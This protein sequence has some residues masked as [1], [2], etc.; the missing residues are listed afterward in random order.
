M[1]FLLLKE[2]AVKWIKCTTRLP[3]E[4]KECLVAFEIFPGEKHA[5]LCYNMATYINGVFLTWELGTTI[6][7]VTHWMPL[8]KSPYK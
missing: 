8:P 5:G 2:Y 1:L 3:N 6:H 7:H 4:E